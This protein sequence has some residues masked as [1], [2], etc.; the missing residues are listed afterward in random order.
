MIGTDLARI[1]LARLPLYGRADVGDLNASRHPRRW[2]I[3]EGADAGRPGAEHLAGQR[4]TSVKPTLTATTS[5]QAPI[6]A[7]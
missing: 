6:A 4:P 5:R 2:R 1:D 7:S 3:L